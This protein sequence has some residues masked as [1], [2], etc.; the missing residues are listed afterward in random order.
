[1]MLDVTT[2]VNGTVWPGIPGPFAS[3]LLA[4]QCQFEA[5]QWL[6][7]EELLARQTRQLGRLLAHAYDTSPFYRRRL[8][9][10]GLPAE[11][12]HGPAEWLRIP[13]LTRSDLQTQH[14]EILSRSVPEA[15]GPQSQ[16]FTSGSTG[17]PVMVVGTGL[18]QLFWNCCTL[19]DHLWHRRA[20]GATLAAIRSLAGEIGRAPEG[21][22]GED[23]G[24]AT[25]GIVNT[26]PSYT[27]SVHSTI[28]EQADWLQRRDPDYLLTYPSNL[29]ALVQHSQAHG[30]RLPRLRQAR[31][32]GELLEPHVRR[33][34]RARWGVGIVDMYS[35]QEVGYIALQCPAQEQYHVQAENVLVEVI[36]EEGRL[37]SPGQI[38]RVVVTAL[39]NFALPLLRYEIGDYA[40]VGEACPCGRGLPVLRRIMGRQRNMA[41]LPDGRRR[42]PAIELAETDELADFPP[43]HQFQLVQRST[44][45]MEMLLV[46]HRPLSAADED[47]LRAWIV[48]AVGYPFEVAFR[49]VDSIPRSPL[50]KFEDFRCEI[51]DARDQERGDG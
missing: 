51:P 50:G 6:S 14:A 35:S 22:T 2:T 17:R 12:V 42:W 36:D 13:L 1:M 33:A 18:T 19:R 10:V 21:L 39:H 20:P 41:I 29:L 25:R 37:C 49:Y 47:R 43:I 44:T 5:I 8:D 31:T 28:E 3:Q 11:R 23:W 9:A 45:A 32:F 48:S 16:L 26:G 40:E 30:W 4:M 34:C 24:P 7:P 15:H 27:L 46:V 38:G